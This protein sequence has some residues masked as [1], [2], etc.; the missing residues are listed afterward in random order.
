ML[1]YYTVVTENAGH[2]NLVSHRLSNPPLTSIR[3]WPAS[4]SL[5][6]ILVLHQF[7]GHNKSTYHLG[8]WYELK[9]ILH[10]KCLQ[11]EWPTVGPQN[12]LT[13]YSMSQCKENFL[14]WMTRNRYLCIKRDVYYHLGKH[15]HIG[16]LS[17]TWKVK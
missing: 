7:N 6:S 12:T 15:I 8:L 5:A 3:T 9:E 10:I 14:G 16:K 17:G 1:R 13:I 2:W 11:N 4:I